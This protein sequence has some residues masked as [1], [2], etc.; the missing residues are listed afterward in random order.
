MAKGV[1]AGDAYI[2]LAIAGG[3]K[4]KQGLK[5]A[6]G[7]LKNLGSAA[8]KVG[9]QIAKIGFAS[10]AALA[11]KALHSFSSFGDQ[12]DK[13]SAR[14]G[15]SVE[16]L[17]QLKFAAEQSGQSVEQLESVM[18]GM[19]RQTRN[20]ERGL[21]TAKEGFGALGL[22]F[23]D[24]QGKSPEDQFLLMADRLKNIEDPTK[25]AGVA[26]EVFGRAGRNLIPLLS[27]GEDGIRAMME[28]ADALGLTLSKK[29]TDAAAVF[30]DKMNALK[31]TANAA[32][33]NIGEALA[34]FAEKMI[35]TATDFFVSWRSNLL[36]FEYAFLKT[37]KNVNKTYDF[38]SDF[39]AGA[40]EGAALRERRTD[41][42]MANER[43]RALPYDIKA[44]EKAD[45]ARRRRARAALEA[46]S[47]PA[48]ENP[49]IEDIAEEVKKVAE[50]AVKSTASSGALS[51]QAFGGFVS[52]GS[53]LPA[54]QLSVA[55][56]SLQVQEEQLAYLKTK[57]LTFGV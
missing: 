52:R 9:S 19:A 34:P 38:Y 20:L 14:T 21:S 2:Q 49:I 56:E 15:A 23:E 37:M 30:T 47:Q 44:A 17:S 33:V 45:E 29:T 57:N 46:A 36:K 6:V 26:M 32:F 28:Q 10:A 43:I 8:L 53:T 54:Q 50:K 51:T 3:D 22:T 12:M 55:K 35:S 7:A 18:I 11:T 48:G 1:K 31:Q 13:M 39:Y 5:K 25:R 27:Q 40:P 41:R 42:A 24:I 4:L 16:A